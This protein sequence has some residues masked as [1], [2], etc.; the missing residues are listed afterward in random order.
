VRALIVSVVLFAMLALAPAA[1]A[2]GRIALTSSASG[3]QDIWVVDPLGG[4]PT[5]LTWPDTASDQSPAWS[6]DYA[7]IAF[8]SDR[9]GARRVWLM[10]ADGSNPK[11]LTDDPGSVSADADPAWSP[12]G[13]QMAFASTRNTG[14]WAIWVVG[15][16]GSGLH[17]LSPG[18]GTS[19]AWSPDGS[20]LAFDSSGAIHVLNADGTAEHALTSGELPDS[21]P[22]WSPDGTRIA[23]ARYR[24]DW[25]TSNVS[26][27]WT[28]GSNGGQP[29]QVTAF[30]AFSDHPSWSPDGARLVFQARPATAPATSSSLATILPNG[31]GL[32][33]V[34]NAP[35]GSF[36]PAW[37]QSRPSID[38]RIPRNGQEFAQNSLV[39]VHYLCDST[40]VTCTGTVP[41]QTQLDTTRPGEFI[42]TVTATDA[43]GH[44]TT[45]TATYRVRDMSPPSVVFITPCCVDPT[46]VI[47]TT[48]ATS[49]SCDDG[50]Y[51]SGV[52]LC[53]GDPYLDTSTIGNHSFVVQTR[54]GLGNT[55]TAQQPYRVIWPFAFA[56]STLEPPTYNVFQA[57]D[58]VPVRFTLGGDRGFDVLE[59]VYYVAVDC[60]TGNAT[61]S[62]GVLGTLSQNGA[63]KI[64]TY[65]WETDSSLAGSCARL[66]FQLRDNSWHEAWIRFK[67]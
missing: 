4:Q 6:P 48:V 33:P 21:T 20:Q 9:S 2:G 7:R 42:F 52:A 36:Q 37:G 27:I 54:D 25:P 51:G 29:F 11:Q 44:V 53:T 57:G 18:V 39:F 46:Y 8:I 64:Y 3:N 66:T 24:T 47:G 32:T 65:K 14:S 12:D 45:T 30:D 22:S 23:F 17:R 43:A 19:P 40:S 49:F 34:G 15:I 26:N 31:G 50:L 13:T 35:P 16:D 38:L 59:T 41:T 10:S 1:L 61:S 63:G 55:G 62:G 67:R 28:V 5:D 60:V 56:P 58:R